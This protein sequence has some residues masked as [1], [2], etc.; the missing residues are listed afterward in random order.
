MAAGIV[1]I[2]ENEGTL[3]IALIKNLGLSDGKAGNS[4]SKTG[5]SL[6]QRP[7]T[8]ASRPLLRF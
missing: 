3:M 4:M 1:V 5:G 6:V 8:H 2:S 7:P